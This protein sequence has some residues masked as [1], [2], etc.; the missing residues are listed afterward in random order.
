MDDYEKAPST[1]IK[2]WIIIIPVERRETV[3]KQKTKPGEQVSDPSII[4]LYTEVAWTHSVTRRASKDK[5]HGLAMP[6]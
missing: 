5:K 4:L 2:T 1:Q 3:E 6:A